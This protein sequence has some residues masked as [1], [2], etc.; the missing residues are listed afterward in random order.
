MVFKMKFILSLLFCASCIFVHAQD[1][2]TLLKEASNFEKQF[3]EPEALEKYRQAVY[4]DEKNIPALVKC[5][6][7]NCSIGARQTDKNAKNNYYQL[8]KTFAEKALSADAANAD[9]NY[10][11][12][13][14]ESKMIETATE[15]KEIADH[16]RQTK[17]Y[18]DKALAINP[19]QSK[20]NY[21]AGK[22]HYEMSNLN[23]L[24]KAAVKA[25]YGLPKGDIDSA[26]IYM[27]KCKTLDQ[28]FV[29]NYLDLAKAYQYKQQPAKEMDVLKKLVKLPTRTAD[30]VALKQEGEKMLNEML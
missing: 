29:R 10:A 2:N 15:N 14:V 23:W 26:I 11:M 13:L 22:W 27:E 30:D 19:D 16:I 8:A 3:K 5:T 24:K 1:V 6:E 28:Y 18:V 12:A 20:A 9:A 4:I 25:L 7:L 17:L 21:I